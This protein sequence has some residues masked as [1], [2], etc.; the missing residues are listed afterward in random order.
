MRKANGNR[1]ALDT[2]MR[3]PPKIRSGCDTL[4]KV[5]TMVSVAKG[6]SS[7]VGLANDIRPGVYGK[8]ER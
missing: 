6:R 8:Q 7:E 1:A 2:G 3:A 5:I 4:R